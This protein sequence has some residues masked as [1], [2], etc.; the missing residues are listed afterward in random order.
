MLV[1]TIKQGKEKSLLERQPWI[2][3]SAVERV[4]GRP[5]ERFKPGATA[6]VRSSKGVFLARAAY[7]P[8]SQIRARVWSFREDEAVD[9]ALIKRRVQT[10]L[11]KRYSGKQFAADALVPVVVG[12]EDGLS[13]LSVEYFNRAPGYLICRF[14]SAGVD[15]WKVAIVQS[16]IANTGCTNVYER[17][18]ELL[19]KGEGLT[20]AP[21]PL[22]GDEPP[23]DAVVTIKGTRW[24]LDVC[25][26]E[27]R[28]FR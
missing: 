6:V 25:T 5:D 27:K 24:L 17:A 28:P 1:I 8:Q 18:D 19:R 12:E 26:G 22:A 13:G 11:A 14:E 3:A 4:D 20:V 7:S 16:L 15:A 10:A 23:D 9:H 21:G 2:Y